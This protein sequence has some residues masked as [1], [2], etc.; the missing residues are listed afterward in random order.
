MPAREP[1]EE[2]GP[3][4]VVE[5]AAARW[6]GG[7]DAE[8]LDEPERAA[9]RGG[10]ELETLS[11][12][13]RAVLRPRIRLPAPPMQ[14]LPG[15]E[16]GPA[17]RPPRDEKDV[18]LDA[19]SAG[20]GGARPPAF[21]KGGFDRHMSDVAQGAESSREKKGPPS[22][23]LVVRSF[24]TLKD[25]QG[26]L[27]VSDWPVWSMVL[28]N[29]LGRDVEITVRLEEDNSR[30]RL[31][32]RE[33]VSRGAR[34]R[35][36]FY[37]PGGT[38]AAGGSSVRYEVR[39]AEGR[40]LAGSPSAEPRGS[41]EANAYQIGL[42]SGE[43]SSS[44][45]F[46]FPGQMGGIEVGVARL[47]PSIFPD[48][49]IGLSCLD[50][51]VLHDSP[52][53]ELTPDQ[54]R[55]LAEYVRGGGTV[56]LSPGPDRGW[57]SH[58]ALTAFVTIHAGASM[59][60]TDLPSLTEHFG[61]FRQGERF[62]YHRIENG[63]E[64]GWGRESLQYDCGFGRAI[65]LPFDIRRPPLETWPGLEKFWESLL[66]RLPRRF[67]SEDPPTLPAAT[68]EASLNLF[69]SMALL[70]NPYP[71]FLLL[72]ALAVLFLVAVGPVNYLVLRRMGMTLL[73]VLTVP[74]I[75]GF[76][77]VVVFVMGY[78]LKGTMTVAYSARILSTRSGLDCA[79]EK[80]LFTLF[81]PSTRS[82]EISVAPG[83][84]GLP[85]DRILPQDRRP[86]REDP[87][88]GLDRLECEDGPSVTY[89]G[90][91]VGQWQ[92]WNLQARAFRDLGGGVRF[93]SAGERVRISNL[94]PYAIERGL[95]VTTGPGGHAS[96]FGE[97]P[98]GKDLDVAVG[99]DP[100]SPLE[101]LGITH[102]SLEGRVLGPTL[103]PLVYEWRRAAP[104][105]GARTARIL[106]CV[107]KEEEPRVKVDARLSGSSRSLTLLHVA[108]SPAR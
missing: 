85:L 14:N 28:E 78:V 16:E 75:S 103:D 10:P 57:L 33:A 86:Y 94:S 80:Q 82:Y 32:R 77:L 67:A 92:S 52:L 106:L 73:V 45:G 65:V 96:P 71:S 88:P 36:F 46:G 54:S 24:E 63:R 105:E 83:T 101:E 87:E 62:V 51:L 44:H 84:N 68:P 23:G 29:E 12:S 55:A 61:R 91:T 30:V 49:A 4:P 19:S 2:I 27:L 59:E 34:K 58:K 72:V 8:A 102:E 107:L 66:G 74:A 50:V 31:T 40:K 43:K 39:D 70:I 1:V 47:T 38:F 26:R 15:M 11:K 6:F 79:R 76:F 20:G 90:V 108:E 9:R 93:E 69:Q 25:A 98:P 5:R 18:L 48:R 41:L 42:F 99:A 64:M 7:M 21:P 100:R 35:L 95:L 13:L 97:I 3:Y 17:D 81:S 60:R 89:R 53:D 56:V 22:P 37:F 104:S